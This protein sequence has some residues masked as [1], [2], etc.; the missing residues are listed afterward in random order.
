MHP[1]LKHP[2]TNKYVQNMQSRDLSFPLIIG[3]AKDT[4]ELMHE[5]FKDFLDFF[6]KKPIDIPAKDGCPR[7]TNIKVVSPQDMKS[8]WTVM[9]IGGGTKKYFC[10]CCICKQA[11]KTHF[12]VGELRCKRCKKMKLMLLSPHPKAQAAS[13]VVFRR[14]ERSPPITTAPAPACLRSEVLRARPGRARCLYI[15]E[16]AYSRWCSF[17]HLNR[18]PTNPGGRRPLL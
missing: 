9:G 17:L 7:Y 3:F 12:K 1:G 10:I 8:H 11:E 6:F 15:R 2:Q 18:S 13:I 16:K 5:D 14:G 4:A